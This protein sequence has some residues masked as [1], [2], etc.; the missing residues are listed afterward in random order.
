[1]GH[2][3]TPSDL[4]RPEASSM[5]F[6]DF[7]CLLMYRLVLSCV[8]CCEAFCVHVVSKFFCSPVFGP[9]LGLY[10]RGLEL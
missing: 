9:R 1:M 2:L 4:T 5:I 10:L 8:I 6:P 3:L 7:F